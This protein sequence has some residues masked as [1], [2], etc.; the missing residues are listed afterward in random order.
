VGQGLRRGFGAAEKAKLWDWWQQGESL[1]AIGRA[2]GKPSS[3]IYF[4]LAPHGGIRPAP[5]RRSRLALTLLEREEISR[6]IAAAETARSMARKLGR[7]PS[8]VAREINRNGGYGQY[9]ASQA[10]ETAWVGQWEVSMRGRMTLGQVSLLACLIALP[11]FAQTE[12]QNAAALRETNCK[13]CHGETGDSPSDAVPR[14][15]GQRGEYLRSRLES[16]RY[17][18]RE[19]PRMIHDMG[20]FSFQ[21]TTKTIAEL[22]KFYAAQTPSPQGGDANKEG[23]AL[24]RMG[25]K[26]IPACRTC[27]GERGEGHDAVPRL[28][29]QHKAYLQMQLQ[30]FAMAARIADPMN[31]HVW[32]MTSKEQEALAAYL[33]N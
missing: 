28:A 21:L 6:G 16:F 30:G 20:H 25:A 22:A 12:G 33:G 8:T 14:L 4:Q 29:G 7:S 9:R 27:H 3:S 2:F 11:A 15:N 18:I 26:D 5:R 32:V 19:S 13:A 31:H 24:Y 1:K 17:P 10:E 23:G